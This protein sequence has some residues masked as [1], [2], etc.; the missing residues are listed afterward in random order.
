MLIIIIIIARKNKIYITENTEINLIRSCIH[1]WQAQNANRWA[2]LH[3][4]VGFKF[5]LPKCD[6]DNLR[7]VE[8]VVYAIRKLTSLVSPL[9]FIVLLHIWVH[10]ELSTC[11]LVLWFS[12]H[13]TEFHKN[14][15]QSIQYFHFRSMT[16]ES[17]KV[18]FLLQLIQLLTPLH[19]NVTD[20]SSWRHLQEFDQ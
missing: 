7:F 8:L 2:K 14:V 11:F 5:I 10:I 13:V 18:Y 19:W 20:L 1:L 15:V 4:L 16:S 12:L 3:F 17:C 6:I 9:L